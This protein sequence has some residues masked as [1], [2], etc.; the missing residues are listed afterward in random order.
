MPAGGEKLM[1]R[2]GAPAWRVAPAAPLGGVVLLGIG[3]E[4]ALDA[5]A[6]SLL[7]EGFAVVVPDLW[8]RAAPGEGDGLSDPE[9]I[10]DIAAAR[11]L[12]P[13]G[14]RFVVG[15]GDGGL[16]ARMAACAVLGLAGAID[17]HGPIIYAGVSARR[18]IQPLDLLP[19][20][21]CTLQVHAVGR[22]PAVP[23]HHVEALERRLAGTSCGWQILHYPNQEPG[24]L[25]PDRAAFDA[26]AAA[27]AW[28]RGLSFLLHVAAEGG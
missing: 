1:S 5:R 11:D 21:S 27:L 6:A 18:P 9:A 2:S 16:H 14:P 23:P 15:F 19:G 25:E 4:A 22:D 8:W 3:P 24:F 28:S 17:Y 10:A 20:L 13:R 7:A 26:D 12:L